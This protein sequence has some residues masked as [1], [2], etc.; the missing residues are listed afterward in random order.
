MTKQITNHIMMIRPVA[1][2]LNAE[3]AVN[4]YYQ[5]S[6]EAV[7]QE[8]I[9]EDA[10]R[11]FN[12]FVE[13]LRKEGVDVTV[14]EDTKEPLTPDSIFPNNWI[15]FHADG[16]IRLY[17]MFAK[18]RRLERRED[19]IQ[20]IKNQFTVSNVV[21]L[22]DWESKGAYLEG[23]GSL[24]LD[25]EN[26]I[27]Y[28]AL[29]AR[30]MA[31]VLDDFCRESGYQSVLFHANQTVE[32]KRLPIYH[33]NVMMCLGEEFAVVCLDSIDDKNE[34]NQLE[35]SL[36]RTKKEII[37][38]TEHQ[39]DQFAGNMLQVIGAD[40]QRLVVMSGAAYRSLSQ[41]QIIQLEKH[42][43]IIHSDI[44]TIEKLGGGSARCMMAEIFL[45]K[46]QTAQE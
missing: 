16:A 28:A 45:H 11:E 24:L 30:T 42:G 10:L 36:H 18:N 19:I 44:P 9:Q 34:R 31:V 40:D 20:S 35:E 38:I 14:F 4:N 41:D 27:A 15:S 8:T 22:T 39:K 26:K 32:G 2:H 12:A 25:R 29:S 6:K 21:S 3:T 13:K 23:T 46:K 1:F 43:K 7:D 33:T 17:P 37:E 5:K